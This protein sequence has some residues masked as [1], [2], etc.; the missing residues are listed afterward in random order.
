M[1][2]KETELLF[3]FREL[4][5]VNFFVPDIH[6]DRELQAQRQKQKLKQESYIIPLKVF[7]RPIE[8][9]DLK[10]DYEYNLNSADPKYRVRLNP[11]PDLNEQTYG[12][13]L[14]KPLREDI[15]KTEKDLKKMKTLQK[16][17]KVAAL[18]KAPVEEAK[19][20]ITFQK[21]MSVAN[22]EQSLAMDQKTQALVKKTYKK[23]YEPDM[24]FE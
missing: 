6:F 22:L 13:Y 8:T 11:M 24:P 10:Y 3:I 1:S 2:Q 9:K 15:L 19:E 14:A 12:Q 23:P 16:G 7:W 21:F 20:D 4:M 5:S 17:K 18:H